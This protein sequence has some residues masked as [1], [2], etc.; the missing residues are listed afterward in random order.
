M[1]AA[2]FT[3]VWLL[4]YG[5]TAALFALRLRQ[6]APQI[7][8]LTTFTAVMFFGVFGLLATLPGYRG[9]LSLVVAVTCVIVG[10]YLQ[11]KYSP[12]TE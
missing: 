10:G 1:T 3:I 2:A 6:D 9:F 5:I 7:V 12:A 4:L 11:L 8:R